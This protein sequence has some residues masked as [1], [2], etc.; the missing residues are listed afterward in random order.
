M[1]NATEK[2]VNFIK[3]LLNEKAFTQSDAVM[4]SVEIEQR[5][6]KTLGSEIDL[7]NLEGISSY[8]ASKLIDAL[9]AVPSKAAAKKEA[10]RTVAN[11][12]AHDVLVAEAKAAGFKV[13]KNMRSSTIRKIMAGESTKKERQTMAW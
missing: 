6:G 3:R 10:E 7:D 9:L 13:S 8:E 2:Q 11:F 4:V 5:S 1:A 12:A